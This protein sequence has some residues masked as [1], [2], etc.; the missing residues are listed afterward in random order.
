MF[1]GQSR[2]DP[3][4]QKETDI[5]LLSPTNSEPMSWPVGHTRGQTVSYFPETKWHAYFV[6]TV[7]L[8]VMCTTSKERGNTAKSKTVFS[9][10]GEFPSYMY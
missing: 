2:V 7:H 8:S 5:S 1:C 9:Y 10:Y 3:A 4:V 6:A